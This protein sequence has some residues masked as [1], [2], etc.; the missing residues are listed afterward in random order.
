MLNC[1]DIGTASATTYFYED[2]EDQPVTSPGQKMQLAPI[3]EPYFYKPGAQVASANVVTSP[4]PV[5]G[6]KSFE[7]VRNGQMGP[8]VGAIS[9]AGA[10]ADGKTMEIDWNHELHGGTG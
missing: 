6:S 5:I 3:G 7:E 10:I 1:L 9:N 8:D 4:L 2:F